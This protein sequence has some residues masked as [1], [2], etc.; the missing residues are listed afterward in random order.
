MSLRG[1][2]QLRPKWPQFPQ[3]LDRR[4]RHVSCMSLHV[5]VENQVGLC[6]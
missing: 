2:G 4:S 5:P 6:A 1:W 3:T